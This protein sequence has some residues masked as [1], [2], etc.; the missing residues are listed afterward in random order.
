MFVRHLSLTN[1]RS[2]SRL[3]LDLSEHLAVLEGGNAQ[4]KTNLLE[5]IYLLA[6]TRS[7]LV[8]NESELIN[9]HAGG[10]GPLVARLFAEVQRAGGRIQV[11]IAWQAQRATMP[12]RKRIRVNGV[13]RRVVDLVG[14]INVVMFSA[15]DIDLIGGA[16]ALRR[17]YLDIASSQVDS[18]YLYS[19]QRYN[20]VLA[21]RNHLLRLIR[22]RR[23]QPAE[24]DFWDR[25]LAETGSY[26][27]VQ[28]RHLVATLSDL[29]HVLHR[30][31][32]AGGEGLQIIYL[33]GLGGGVLGSDWQPERVKPELEARLRQARQRELA[34]GMTL[35]GPHRDDIQFLVEG[36]DMNVYGSRGQQRTVALSLRLAEA[37]FML[38]RGGEHP[39]LLLDDVL[40]E[41]DSLRRRHLLESVSRYQQV[42]ITATDL[43]GFEPD[44]LAKAAQFRVDGGTVRPLGIGG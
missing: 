18:R 20:R 11:E 22:D 29:A 10:E 6:T 19:L 43:D 39:I 26:L 36:V 32:T 23:A 25:E 17:R 42:L 5:A 24:L 35:V 7:P 40:S 44:F 1:F 16:P 38:G 2:Y 33:P 21:Q 12:V 30:Q 28:R 41:L 15:H 14:Q 9:W 31:L 27:T 8:T 37:E 13:V 34:L 4:G 3:E